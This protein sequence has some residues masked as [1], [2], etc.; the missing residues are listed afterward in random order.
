[1]DRST[2]S[3]KVINEDFACWTL[4]SLPIGDVKVATCS[5]K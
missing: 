2:K 5:Q 3:V 4:C 1:M